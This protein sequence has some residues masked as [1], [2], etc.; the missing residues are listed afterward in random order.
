MTF[1]SVVFP[2]ISHHG[3]LPTLIS[4]LRESYPFFDSVCLTVS[5]IFHNDIFRTLLLMLL[6]AYIAW[7]IFRFLHYSFLKKSTP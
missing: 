1:V 2:V 7:F 3:S 6:V 5:Y 4:R